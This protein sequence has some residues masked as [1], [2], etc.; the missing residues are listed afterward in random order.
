MT[1]S[2]TINL[3]SKD[4]LA[5]DVG[6]FHDLHTKAYLDRLYGSRDIWVI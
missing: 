1:D 3:F 5:S 2:F 4:I 6:V